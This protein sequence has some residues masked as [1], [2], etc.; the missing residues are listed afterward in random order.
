[1]AVGGRRL[2]TPAATGACVICNMKLTTE[3]VLDY[4]QAFHRLDGYP[5]AVV[6]QQGPQVVM[7]S[8]DLSPKVKW[9]CVV[10]REMLQPIKDAFEAARKTEKQKI[11]ALAAGLDPKM[12]EKERAALINKQEHDSNV[13]LDKLGQQENEVTGLLR[14]PG[15]GIRIRARDPGI[16]AILALI[17]KDFID[18]EPDYGQEKPKGEV[19]DA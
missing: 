4:H 17:R 12:D 2:G 3:K 11:D 8:F 7:D 9:R 16:I 13:L 6:T 5:R 19:K 18:G 14:L 1:M 15:E 10:N